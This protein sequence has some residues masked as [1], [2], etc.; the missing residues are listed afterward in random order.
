[1]YTA[2]LKRKPGRLIVD[3]GLQYLLLALLIMHGR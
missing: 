3:H 2:V 1:M